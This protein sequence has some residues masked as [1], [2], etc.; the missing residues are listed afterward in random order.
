MTQN[1]NADHTKQVKG[2]LFEAIVRSLL[3]WS[4]FI[5]PERR[6]NFL[7]EFRELTEAINGIKTS[8]IGV[9][10]SEKEDV[11]YPIHLLSNQ[12]FPE[13]DF[14]EGD[15]AIFRPHYE[16][17]NDSE[18]GLVFTINI[19]NAAEERPWGYCRHSAQKRR[20]DSG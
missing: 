6:A 20:K 15:S 4:N 17:I 18:N 10:A 1:P 9:A 8:L 11:Q 14:A 3:P 5:I 2:A 16:P 19:E 7:N 12:E 13:G